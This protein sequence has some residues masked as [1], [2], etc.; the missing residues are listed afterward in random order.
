MAIDLSTDYGHIDDFQD[1]IIKGW[2]YD[3]SLGSSGVDIF[4][5]DAHIGTVEADQYRADLKENGVGDGSHGFIF[6][7][8]PAVL[9]GRPQS[10]SARIAGTDKVLLGCPISIVGTPVAGVPDIQVDNLVVNPM[11]RNLVAAAGQINKGG[12]SI[13]PGI[14][15]E[16]G[17]SAVEI[18]SYGCVQFDGFQ[19]S[20]LGTVL[21]GIR[22]RSPINA[23]HIRLFFDLR[24]PRSQLVSPLSLCFAIEKRHTEK[25]FEAVVSIGVKANGEIVRGWRSRINSLASRIQ[26]FSFTVP[27]A[28]LNET[29]ADARSQSGTP[30]LM[31]DFVG[32]SDLVVSSPNLVLGHAQLS[33]AGG[34]V[35][36]FEA[37]EVRTQWAEVSEDRAHLSQTE[38]HDDSWVIHDHLDVPEVI[39]PAFNSPKAVGDCLLALRQNTNIPHLVTLV[40]DGSFS[41]TTDILDRFAAGNP[42]CR[43]LHGARNEGY[44][45]AVNRAIKSAAGKVFVILNSDTLVTPGWLGGLV[46]CLNETA[47]TGIAGPLSNAASWQSIPRMKDNENWYVNQLA[48]GETPE[49]VA[50][51]VRKIS[52]RQFPE[53]SVVNGFCFAVK[54]EVIDAIGLFDE[55]T[56]PQGYGEENDF[57]LRAADAGFKMRI[58]DHVYVYHH[59]SASFG[60]EHRAELSKAANRILMS[61]YGEERMKALNDGMNNISAIEQIREHLAPPQGQPTN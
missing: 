37:Y 51:V 39:I 50:K 13:A 6:A 34:P 43:V 32:A 31:F 12:V 61:R 40:N 23:S 17:K 11:I 59:K 5:D 4:L 44:T 56:F 25:N 46:E 45:R 19:F 18:S 20:A 55:I 54:R 33:S 28:V 14:R 16:A 36:D 15:V 3:G 24:K 8:P 29:A 7:V 38:V 2:A 58:A 27:P 1:N 57:C 41:E 35:R 30:I 22:L 49:S 26:E 53:V 21:S 9:T 48:E 47:D 42:W 10:L 52:A 60:P